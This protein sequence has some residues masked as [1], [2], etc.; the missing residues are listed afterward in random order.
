[1]AK[2]AEI[3]YDGE[4]TFCIHSVNWIRRHDRH[5]RL[6]YKA[7]PSGATCVTLQDES[8]DWNASTA[9]LRALRHLGGVWRVIAGMLMIVPRPI[10]DA[11]YRIIARHRHFTGPGGVQNNVE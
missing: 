9:V 1:M 4:C 5:C 10:R 2:Q 6:S 7:L 3:G 11:V 8:G